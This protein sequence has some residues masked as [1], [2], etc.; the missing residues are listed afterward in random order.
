MMP[1]TSNATNQGIHTKMW[2]GL[3]EKGISPKVYEKYL[4]RK[5]GK[6]ISIL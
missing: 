3:E 4:I 1:M 5:Y 6:T 2:Q